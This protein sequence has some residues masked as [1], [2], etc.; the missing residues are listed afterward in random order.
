MNPP[1]G[2]VDPNGPTFRWLTGQDAAAPKGTF[3]PDVI[4]A[5]K[6][7]HT[8]YGIPASVTLAQWALESNWGRAMPSG[9]NNPFGIKAVGDQPYVEASTREVINGESRIVTA[10][11]R[12]FASMD[13]AFDQHGKLLGH[14]HPY[15]KARTVLP[16][17]ERFA[18][19]LT[20][21]YATDPT[22]GTVLK[23][24]MRSHNLEQY[25]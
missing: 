10:R 23:G 1:D 17:A 4:A 9:S 11:F 5:A 15:I 8:K 19:E 16:D 20:G 3:P 12:R 24:I 25:D 18:D 7:S 21:V 22:Y 13:E 14:G 6:L 2:R